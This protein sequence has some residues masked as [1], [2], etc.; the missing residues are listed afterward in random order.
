M[1]QYFSKLPNVLEPYIGNFDYWL[2]DL[3]KFSDENLLH[4]RLGFLAYGLLTMKHSQDKAWLA[5]Q[6]RLVFE[7]GEDFLGTERGRTFVETL[8]VY[9]VRIANLEAHVVKNKIIENMA[10]AAKRA[11]VSTYDKI[12]LE[13][14]IEGKIEQALLVAEN[15]MREFPDLTDEKVVRLSGAPLDEVRSLRRRLMPES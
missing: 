9:F 1:P 3:S 6:M 10:Q 4:L 5:D 15:L 13:G 14:K 8:F 7:K 11:F 12:K 2:V